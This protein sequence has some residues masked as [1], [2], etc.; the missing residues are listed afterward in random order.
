MTTTE[1]A[2][3][4]TEQAPAETPATAASTKGDY[5][6]YV[7]KEPTNLHRHYWAWIQE[8]T[9][10]KLEVDDET[11]VKIIQI[12]VSAYQQYQASPENKQRRVDE[13]A[14]K[15]AAAEE[16]KAKKAL[17]AKEKAEAKA[18]AAEAAKTEAAAAGDTAEGAAKRQPPPR[19]GAPKAN[20]ANKAAQG[21]APF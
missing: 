14:Q 1:T 19:K 5:T 9:G 15:A 12:A 4:S 10:I 3:E 11:A 8:K 6:K 7:T 18:A 17:A 2:P 13:A 20:A 21:E 16:A